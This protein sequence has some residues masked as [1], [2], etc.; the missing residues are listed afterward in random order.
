MN[1]TPNMTLEDL[2]Q[3]YKNRRMN[4]IEKISW[5]KFLN[6]YINDIKTDNQER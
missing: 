4:G 3:V 5:K 1:P 2:K 6:K